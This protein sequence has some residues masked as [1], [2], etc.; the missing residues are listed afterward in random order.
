MYSNF[1]EGKDPKKDISYARKKIKQNSEGGTVKLAYNK[2]MKNY[3]Y[4]QKTYGI[5]SMPFKMGGTK[6][7]YRETM[8]NQNKGHMVYI[9]KFPNEQKSQLHKPVKAK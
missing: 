4:L 6:H 8:L 3:H 7:T 5:Q 2:N 9:V 1:G